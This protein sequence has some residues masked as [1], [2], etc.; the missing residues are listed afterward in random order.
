MQKAGGLPILTIAQL[1]GTS[2]A[3]IKK[4]YGHLLHDDVEEALATLV[5]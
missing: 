4:H 1:S 3:M 2:L 5:I